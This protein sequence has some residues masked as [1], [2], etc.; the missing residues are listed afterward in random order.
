MISNIFYVHSS[1]NCWR[2]K[3]FRVIPLWKKGFSNSIQAKSQF[4]NEKLDN[5]PEKKNNY[6][7]TS[8]TATISAVDFPCLPPWRHRSDEQDES[9]S[10]CPFTK[11]LIFFFKFN[12]NYFSFA[13]FKL[14]KIRR[15]YYS[16]RELCGM[17]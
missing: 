1:E 7:V 5:D 11:T 12:F 14:I 17:M 9:I 6:D 10:Q 4:S 2:E 16:S 13:S 8:V 15:F 3:A